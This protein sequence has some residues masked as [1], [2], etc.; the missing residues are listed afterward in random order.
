MA[1][2]NSASAGTSARGGASE[3]NDGDDSARHRVRLPHFIVHEPVGA[4]GVVTRLTSAVGIR[5]CEPC[6]KRAARL[7]RWLRIEP[8]S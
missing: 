6:K 7:D 2:K 4:G 3:T 5:P 1:Q 8:R